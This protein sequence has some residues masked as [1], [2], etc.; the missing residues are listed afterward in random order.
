MGNLALA[1]LFMAVVMYFL[2]YF[3]GFH[4]GRKFDN[5]EE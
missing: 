5:D 4:A 3:L 2:G 1:F